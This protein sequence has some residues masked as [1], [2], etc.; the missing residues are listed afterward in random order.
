MKEATKY[1]SL[2]FDLA[3]GHLVVIHGSAYPHLDVAGF[4][5]A[6]K[7]VFGFTSVQA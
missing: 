7:K 4:G 6:G 1:K 3:D 2:Q 5:D